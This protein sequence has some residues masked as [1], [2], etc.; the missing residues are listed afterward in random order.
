LLAV[1]A[2]TIE[3][4][5]GVGF[6]FDQTASSGYQPLNVKLE[7]VTTPANQDSRRKIPLPSFIHLIFPQQLF[8][9][10]RFTADV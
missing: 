1:G 10:Q 8:G 3:R 5:D 9:L 7:V 2:G 6:E 4:P